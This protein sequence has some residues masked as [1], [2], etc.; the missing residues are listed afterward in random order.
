[1]IEPIF[2][3]I[4]FGVVWSQI[5][6][7]LGASILLHRHYCH[8]QFEVPAWFEVLGLAMLMIAVIRTPIGWIASHRMHHHHSDSEKDPH[9]A[10]HVG[11]WKVLFTTWDI[12]RIPPRYARDL[13]AN[14]RL[15]FC[16]N[17]WGKIWIL[18]WVI[19]FLISPYFFVAFALV[20]FIFAK[21]GFGLLNTV[22]HK[23]GPA[24]VPWLNFFIAGEGYHKNHHDDN[25]KIV[26]HKY[27][28]AGVIAKKLFAKGI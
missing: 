26:L 3:A 5:I 14:P 2:I 9:S 25:S 20:P 6:S 11:F 16:H 8:K 22:G 12:P 4:I 15:L 24:N 21:I 10:K 28:T 17:H 27:D 23:N 19:S 13:F 1:M 7:H 18:N